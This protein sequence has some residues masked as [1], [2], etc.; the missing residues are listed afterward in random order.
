MVCIRQAT[1]NDLLAMQAGNLLCLPENY[2]MK[3]YLYHILSWP[4]LLFVAEDYD[5]RIVGYVLAKMEE[6]ASEPCHGHITSL[7][8]L[9]THRKLGLATKLMTAAQNAM[10]SV[11]GAEYVSLHV[12]RSN[13]AAFTLY[14]SS[15]SYRIHDVEAKYYADG[16]DAYDMRKQLK[17]RPHGH[18]HSHGHHHHHHGGCCSGESKAASFVDVSVAVDPAAGASGSNSL[19]SVPA[20]AAGE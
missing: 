11:F 3:Y 18:S 9:R 19:A 17:G 13:R 12:R 4:Q 2:Q 7:A 20:S 10:E 1:V 16:E 14:T 5:G 15:L 8:V 6:D